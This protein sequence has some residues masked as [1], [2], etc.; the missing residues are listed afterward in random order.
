[1]EKASKLELDDYL[2]AKRDKPC[3]A[4][5]KLLMEW[6]SWKGPQPYSEVEQHDA[7]KGNRCEYWPRSCATAYMSCTL[8]YGVPAARYTSSGAA[9]TAALFILYKDAH[10]MNKHHNKLIAMKPTPCRHAEFRI[11]NER[12]SP[13]VLYSLLGSGERHLWNKRLLLSSEIAMGRMDI[14]LDK[15]HLSV[16]ILGLIR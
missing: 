15:K 12:P 10:G 13:S 14:W 9:A 6:G 7:C 16:R 1:M 4:V 5:V 2:N 11:A 8:H 3:W